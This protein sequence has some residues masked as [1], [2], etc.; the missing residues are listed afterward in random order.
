M[1]QTVLKQA[2]VAAGLAAS[3]LCAIDASGQ[4]AD[5]LLDKLVDKGILTTTEA[6]E[7]REEADAGFRKSYQVKSGMPDWVTALKINGDFRGRFETFYSQNDAFSER[8]RWRYRLRAGMVATFLDNFEA[9]FRLT[10]GEAVGTF[11][12]DPISGNTTLRDNGAK[13]FVYLD[14]AYG[15]WTFINNKTLNGSLTIGKMENPF[16]MSDLMFDADYTPEGAGANVIYNINDV[17]SIRVNGGAFLLD[18]LA[19]DEQDP[20][21]YG[22]QIR[23]DA[24]WTPHLTSSIAAALLL[25]ENEENLTSANVPNIQG[26]NT[27]DPVTTAPSV[28]FNPIVVD[29]ALIYTFDKVPFYKGA[30]P[31]KLFGDYINNVAA[32]DRNEGFQGGITFGKSGKRGTW[33]VTYRYKYMGGDMW[34]EEM[35]DSDWGAFYEAAFPNSG[36]AAGYVAGTNLRGHVARVAYSP[37]DAL[38]LTL[39][40]YRA[41]NINESPAGSNSDMTRIQ[42]DASL[43]F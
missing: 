37:T 24:K 26:G 8:T 9:G 30:F 23:W 13:K 36:L 38:T 14:L 29:A 11:G 39:S 1:K 33:D 22:G 31:V 4:S 6:N 32:D 16:Q 40:Y 43:K 41:H 42:M 12:G 7:L 28:N 15:R 25:I 20:Y 17:H 27:R 2:A 19:A 18:E 5:A 21:M 35:T 10:S 3:T 34:Y